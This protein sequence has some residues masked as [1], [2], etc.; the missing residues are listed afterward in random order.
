MI[1]KS[2]KCPMCNTAEWEWDPA[3]GGSHSA[4]EPVHKFCRGCYLKHVAGETED[5]M[6]G[7]SV[8]LE[9][10]GTVE[11]ARRLRAQRRAYE[12]DQRSSARSRVAGRRG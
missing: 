4:Y 3:Q 2:E 5:T 11:S 9:P 12:R 7:T 10:S 1:A 6:P 8:V